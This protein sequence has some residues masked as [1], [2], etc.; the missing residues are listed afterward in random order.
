VTRDVLR[1]LGKRELGRILHRQNYREARE[2]V[3]ALLDFATP[4]P[5]DGHA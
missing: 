3:V 2:R 5:P 1:P 4:P